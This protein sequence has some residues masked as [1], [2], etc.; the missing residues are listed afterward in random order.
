MEN[1]KFKVEAEPYLTTGVEQKKTSPVTLAFR[2]NLDEIVVADKYHPIKV[3]TDHN[4][5]PYPTIHLRNN[6]HAL[7]S[8]SDFYQLVDLSSS[9]PCTDKKD[10]L[11]TICT[12]E[13]SGCQFVLGKY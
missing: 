9:N 11:D 3:I 1:V 7:I 10:N 12:I 8:R 2:T 5:Q 13:S 4:D 6:L